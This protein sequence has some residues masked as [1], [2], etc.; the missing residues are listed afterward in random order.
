MGK[1]DRYA[2]NF[3]IDKYIVPLLPEP[4]L[5]KLPTIVSRWFGY[6]FKPIRKL[7]DGM[8]W[9]WTWIGAFASIV[10]IIAVFQRDSYFNWRGMPYI[11]GS[12]GASAVLIFGTIE[13]PFAQPRNVFIGHTLSA[14]TGVIIAKLFNTNHD[15]FIEYN[16]VAAGIAVGCATVIML[17]TK[18]VHPPA[19]GTGLLAITDDAIS[20]LGWYYI[21]VVMLSSVLMLGVALITNNIQRRYPVYWVTAVDYMA[22]RNPPPPEEIQEEEKKKVEYSITITPAGIHIPDEVEVPEEE[23]LVLE[24][25]QGK[26]DELRHFDVESIKSIT[27]GNQKV[28]SAK[29]EV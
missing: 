23:M 26:L 18:T 10:V 3:D 12:F 9:L 6:R 8:N 17:M 29:S 24:A 28:E 14:L 15:K 11:V 20:R 2:I 22:K 16:W 27:N 13:A 1:L 21:P 19:G 25:L 4:W 5:P 7:S